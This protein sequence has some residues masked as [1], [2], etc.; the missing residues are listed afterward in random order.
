MLAVLV[1]GV[2][3][4]FSTRE[5]SVEI[6]QNP[7]NT[8]VV[9]SA[10]FL[11]KNELVSIYEKEVPVKLVID[12]NGDPQCVV[13]DL[14]WVELKTVNKDIEA[15]FELLRDRVNSLFSTKIITVNHYY[16][17][18]YVADR[19]W[20]QSNDPWVEVEDP[21][22][23]GQDIIY[24]FQSAIEV[25][26]KNQK[27]VNNGDYDE[28]EGFPTVEM[29]QSND[30]FYFDVSNISTG[31]EL[32]F[33]FDGQRLY[34]LVEGI[35]LED[36]EKLKLA[37][38][39]LPTVEK[40]YPVESLNLKEIGSFV[41]NQEDYKSR[42]T[43]VK[44]IEAILPLSATESSFSFIQSSSQSGNQTHSSINGT[45]D[46][47][48]GGLMMGGWGFVSGNLEGSLDGSVDS[49]P[50]MLIRGSVYLVPKP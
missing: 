14:D 36:A 13:G 33:S 7:N 31:A 50:V 1:V 32:G 41:I 42:D 30:Y 45:Q 4:F 10:S 24:Q 3:F 11:M 19:E 49:K 21:W 48:I 38:Y 17:D 28:V 40:S 26:W 34:D 20:S 6:V 27:I 39:P 43:F 44:I 23:Y 12:E 35:M 2:V 9:Y 46:G 8:T 5:Q 29:T 47:N 16:G 25:P 15:D 22:C 37:K 18:H